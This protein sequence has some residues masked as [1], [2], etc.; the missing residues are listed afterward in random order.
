MPV[1]TINH[2]SKS[3]GRVKALNDLNITIEAGN[4]YGLLG[5]NGSG[6]TTTLGIIL[7]IL[8]QD[9][10][11]FEWFDGVYG[12]KHRLKIGAILETPNFYPYLNAD[13]NLEIIRHIKND[14]NA[15]FDELL[16][17]VN[18]KERRKS[19]FSTFSLGMKQ[20]LA[21]AA[22]LIGNP[23]VL[24]FDEPT[25]GLDPQG[26][27]EVREILQK[28]ARSGKTVIMAS[29]ILDEV[30]KIC[31]HVAIIK[32]GFLLAT[33]PVGSIINSDITVELAANDMTKLKTFLADLPFVKRLDLNGKI[34]EI[35]I[36]KDEDHSVINQMA[37]DQGLLVTQFVARKKRLETEFWKSRQKHNEL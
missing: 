34:I 32:K 24:I 14:N 12:E 37:F 11:D 17:L 5:P 7:G 3:Y 29:H 36:D 31:T 18:L 23:E 16:T 25:N 4:I 9:S 1:L 6:K 27:A 8:K 28:I 35:L 22:T 10:G 26:I 13:E 15:N 2:L 19:K 33:G 21:I 20:R 30:E